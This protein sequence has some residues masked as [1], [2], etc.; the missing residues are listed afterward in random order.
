M[1][2][3]GK[4]TTKRILKKDA[5]TAYKVVR[6]CHCKDFPFSGDCMDTLFEYGLNRS[7]HPGFHAFK[8]QLGA[9]SWRELEETILAVKLYGMV[10][11]GC[12]DGY[13]AMS[14]TRMI[15]EK[16]QRAKR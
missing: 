12:Q 3:T 5:I 4:I 2:L 10:R 8:T 6:L 1:C 11:F 15:I 7:S 9:Q 16:P 13:R 14:A